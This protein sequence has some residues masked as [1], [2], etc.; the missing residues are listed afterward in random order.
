MGPMFHRCDASHAARGP[1]PTRRACRTRRSG[2]FMWQRQYSLLPTA[3]RRWRQIPP[4]TALIQLKQKSSRMS[5]SSSLS[6]IEGAS[7]QPRRSGSA[8]AI[9]AQHFRASIGDIAS[10]HNAGCCGARGVGVWAWG[11]SGGSGST[12]GGRQEPAD[13]A[14]FCHCVTVMEAQR[15]SRTSGATRL[16]VGVSLW[17]GDAWRAG[18]PPATAV[19]RRSAAPLRVHVMIPVPSGGRH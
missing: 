4:R 10:Q 14:N 9:A 13:P 3:S 18:V 1:M 16:T 2:F 5:D 7:R 17:K 6:A 8:F 19:R 15:Q 11:N 12:T